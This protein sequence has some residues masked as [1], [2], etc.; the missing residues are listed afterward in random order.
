MSS[1]EKIKPYDGSCDTC[2]T[3]FSQC[4]FLSCPEC[5]GMIIPDQEEDWEFE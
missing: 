2:E 5:G 4:T 3:I 1:Q